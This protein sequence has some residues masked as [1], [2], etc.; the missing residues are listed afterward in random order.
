MSPKNFNRL[1]RLLLR[2]F[3]SGGPGTSYAVWHDRDCWAFSINEGD[4]PNLHLS[5][6]FINSK[7]VS[8]D[9]MM[10]PS[11]PFYWV[12]KPKRGIEYYV[13]FRIFGRTMR[14]QHFHA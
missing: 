2:I 4:F 9:F 7:S 3:P 6:N 14:M 1:N 8:S 11:C 5:R 12:S 10:D 13:A